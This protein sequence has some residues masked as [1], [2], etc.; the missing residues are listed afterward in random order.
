MRDVKAWH[1]QFP[2]WRDTRRK[3][4]EN[5]YAYEKD[6]DKAP[7][8]VVSSLQ[9]GLCGIMAILYGQGDFVK[10]VGIAVS[11]GYDCDNQAATCGGLIGVL[12]GAEAIPD[13]LTR[14]ISRHG[15]LDE[16]FNNMY[17]NFT[18]DDLPIVTTISDIVERITAISQT[19]ILENGG[20]M[21]RKDDETTYI[22]NCDF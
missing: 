1:K 12:G 14:E 18:R 21:E 4:H 22:I 5:Y 6:G 13:R 2:D 20:R 11:A 19:A 17:I 15:K 3:I 7:V 10:T 9:N 16:P 8:S